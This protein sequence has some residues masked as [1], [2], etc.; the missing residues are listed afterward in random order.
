MRAIRPR[1]PSSAAD[2]AG[3][4]AA[5]V[6]ADGGVHVDLYDAK[7]SVGRKFL[8]AGKGG[9]NLTHAE[10]RSDF[11]S[12]YAER[13]EQIKPLLNVFGP[14]ELRQWAYNLGFDTFVGTSGRVF[15][16]N[17]KAA[18]LLAPGCSGCA[19]RAF[20]FTCATDGWAGTKTTPCVSRHPRATSA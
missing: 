19:V 13:T 18:P 3:L 10:P 5:E 1:S 4:M 8:I 7:P 14:D 2:P 11:L 12:R 6:L 9:L 20:A 17:M 16:T 15:P